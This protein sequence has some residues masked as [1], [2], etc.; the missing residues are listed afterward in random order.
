MHLHALAMRENVKTLKHY[1]SLFFSED[2]YIGVSTGKSR[3]E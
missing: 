3:K 2:I 1:W